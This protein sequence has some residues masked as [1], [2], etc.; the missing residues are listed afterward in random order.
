MHSVASDDAQCM[1]IDIE[2]C[3]LGP[4]M[5]RDYECVR[6]GKMRHPQARRPH[7]AVDRLA[8]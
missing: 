5:E 1:T 4:D 6:I 2:V 8:P 7:A 3:Y